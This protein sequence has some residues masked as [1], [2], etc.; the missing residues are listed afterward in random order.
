MV[1]N[2]ILAA[3]LCLA[4]AEALRANRK[5]QRIK[6]EQA[7]R[8]AEALGSGVRVDDMELPKP[9]DTRWYLDMKTTY[10]GS[11][12]A[13]ELLRLDAIAI[14]LRG[15]LYI[16]PGSPVQDTAATKSYCAS[17]QKAYRSRVARK[18]IESTI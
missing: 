18:S 16:G 7:Q 8:V 9:D 15:S 3:A 10:I 17:V 4:L 13:A 1:L 14:S 5:L 6:I 12:E 2:L 11:S